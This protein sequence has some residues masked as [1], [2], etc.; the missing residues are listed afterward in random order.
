MTPPPDSHEKRQRERR[1]QQKRR[2]KAQRKLQRKQH[3]TGDNPIHH[4]LHR[5]A[6]QH[7]VDTDLWLCV[8]DLVA[9]GGWSP[10]APGIPERTVGDAFARP[11]GLQIEA[12]EAQEL[13]GFIEALLP[14]ISEEELPLSNHPF[15]EEHTED[16]LSRR[17]AGERLALEDASA[18]QE[19]LSG[20]PKKEV[21]LL[22]EFLKAGSVSIEAG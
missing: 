14:T 5:G 3:R 9:V 22:M 18:A 4:T 1:K 8:L 7:R 19:L 11:A 15:G 2:E 16:L 10:P 13:A 12:P 21:Q 17:A 20:A 6:A